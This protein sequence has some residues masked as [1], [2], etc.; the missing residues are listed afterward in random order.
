MDLKKLREQLKASGKQTV[1][2]AFA[3][4]LDLAAAGKAAAEAGQEY[5]ELSGYASTLAKNSQGFKIAAIAWTKPSAFSRIEKNPMVLFNHDCDRPIGQIKDWQPRSDGLW[6]TLRLRYNA[7]LETQEKLGDLVSDGTLRAM[8]IRLDI[9]EYEVIETET[10]VDLI[11][12]DCTLGEVS[13]VSIPSDP[14]A[15]GDAGSEYTLSLAKIYQS[16][17]IPDENKGGNTMWKLLAVEYGMDPEKVTEDIVMT[18][19]KRRKTLSASAISGLGLDPNNFTAE[20]LTA[21]LA[22]RDPKT[23]AKLAAQNLV[24][25]AIIGK[26]IAE[27][28][29]DTKTFALALAESSPEQF[30]AW[31]KLQ[32]EVA[33]PT[34]RITNP[35]SG[36]NLGG[37]TGANDTPWITNED[38]EVCLAFGI[39]TDPKKM[40]EMAETAPNVALSWVLGQNFPATSADKEVIAKRKSW[41]KACGIN[42]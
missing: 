28:D 7:V 10:G 1:T 30:G 35:G 2:L 4:T 38:K 16:A 13:M 8:S 32:K 40:D 31:L 5:I 29:E 9:N 24:N 26:R 14:D 18:E 39:F 12:T 36:S 23:L 37:A 3:D 11:V 19:H 41:D 27:N 17:S 6:V 15:V 34:E 22:A 42:R 25:G 33:P 21:A 20:Q